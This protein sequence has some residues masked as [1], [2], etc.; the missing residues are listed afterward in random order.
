MAS[1]PTLG[2]PLAVYCNCD[3]VLL[4]WRV[5]PLTV[6]KLRLLWPHWRLN[7]RLL[8]AV[9]PIVHLIMFNLHTALQSTLDGGIG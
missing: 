4:R 3:P 2:L 1:K 5:L 9:K 8:V 6:L 7:G